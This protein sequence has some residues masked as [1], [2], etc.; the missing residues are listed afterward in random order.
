MVRSVMDSRKQRLNDHGRHR[1]VKVKRR[2]SARRFTFTGETPVLASL[3]AGFM[4]ENRASAGVSSFMHV[5]LL[6][7]DRQFL[8]IALCRL[9]NIPITTLRSFR[10]NQDFRG[11]FGVAGCGDH[12]RFQSDD[13][14]QA[15]RG[16]DDG[17]HALYFHLRGFVGVRVVAGDD[18]AGDCDERGGQQNCGSDIVFAV[19]AEWGL[20]DVSPQVSVW[21][22]VG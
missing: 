1:A 16:D 10:G 13:L 6:L 7:I 22:R 5:P 15:W 3:S 8:P 12:N 20:H 4:P 14:W 11:F 2:T 18:A 19:G 21:C 17:F 9:M